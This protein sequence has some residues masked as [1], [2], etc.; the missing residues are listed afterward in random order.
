MFCKIGYIY[1]SIIFI[2]LLLL[3]EAKASHIVGGHIE[4]QLLDKAKSLYTIK[5]KLY[6]NELNE[7][8]STPNSYE[9][10]VIC[11]KRGNISVKDIL[12]TKVMKH[13]YV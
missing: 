12:F 8:S 3:N 4:I 5:M 1:F 9:E 7:D 13:P 10:G 6:F 11:Q 2:S